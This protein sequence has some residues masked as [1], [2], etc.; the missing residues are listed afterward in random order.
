MP[1]ESFENAA[2]LAENVGLFEAAT[3]AVPVELPTPEL[4][5][6]HLAFDGSNQDGTARGFAQTLAARTGA[7]VHEQS[8]AAV[9]SDIL[10][11][12]REHAADLLVV[13]APFGRD[14]QLLRDESLGSVV[15]Q[16]LLESTCP[17]LC[18]RE[19][20]TQAQIEAA[21]QRL[22]VP[23]VRQEA[24]V[25]R[26]LGW[27]FRA[28]TAGGRLDLVAVADRGVLEEARRLLGDSVDPETF[29]PEQVLRR[30]WGDIGSL[31]AAAQKRGSAADLAVHVET[32]FGE[33]VPLV[34]AEAGEQPRLIVWGITRDHDAPAFHRAVDLLLESRGPVLM[35]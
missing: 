25:A 9:A 10:A 31:V 16:I 8:G 13:P 34:L 28:L 21:L 15:D 7:V 35:V 1:S 30:L 19:V 2:E 12:A 27:A 33:F 6:V 20:M 22:V 3:H 32:R 17:V 24:S 29:S 18:V 26:A 11:A 5:A 14:Y 23:I 4:R